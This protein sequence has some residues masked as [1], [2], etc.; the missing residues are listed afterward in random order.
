VLDDEDYL[1]EVLA[2]TPLKRIGR[3]E[4]VAAAVA[5]LCMEGA[6]FIT[7]QVVAVD[8]GFSVYGF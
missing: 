2:R 4:E 7:G 6:G 5:F 3:A 8:G 1:R